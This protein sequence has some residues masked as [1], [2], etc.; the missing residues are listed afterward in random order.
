MQNIY[1]K[2]N[3]KEGENM[4]TKTATTKVEF[5]ITCACDVKSLYIVGS[6]AK[7]GEWNP[8][9]AIKVDY[10]DEKKSFY[11]TK[12]L[13]VG[14]SYEFKILADKSW[15][16]VEKGYYGEEIENRSFVVAKGLKVVAKVLNFA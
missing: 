14:A 11:L 3:Y 1:C 13:P 16:R 12:M 8:E 7:F 10:N 15:N 6:D 4:A 9:K 5:F 2:I